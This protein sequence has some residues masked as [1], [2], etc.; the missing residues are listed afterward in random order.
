MTESATLGSRIS[1]QVCLRYVMQ[2]PVAFREYF[3]PK[4]TRRRYWHR[5]TF[6]PP[7]LAMDQG[8]ATLM[9][10]RGSGKSFA[11]LEPEVVRQAIAR[12]GE[13]TMLTSLRKIH[14]V[15]RLER[16][17]DYF[18]G[19]K[20]F[21]VLIAR[22]TRSPSYTI[23]LKTNHSIYGISVGDDPEAKMAQGKHVSTL[24]VE[25]AQQYPE[26][27]WLKLQGAK[28]PRGCRVLM[29]GVPDGAMDTPFRRADGKLSS[30]EGRRFR[31][32]RRYDPYFDKKTK[33]E[34]AENLGGEEQDTFQQE[35][36]AE[37]AN[38]SWS[39]WDL[40]K[41][42][43]CMDDGL[44]KRLTKVAG[45]MY[46]QQ[47]LTPLEVVVDLPKQ[48]HPGA[49][50]YIAMDVGYSQPSEIGVLEW[51][52]DQW[53]LI[54]R[55][56]LIDRMEHDDQAKIVNELGKWYHA[57]KIAVDTTEGEGRAIA[58]MLEDG[59]SEGEPKWKERVNRVTFTET[60]LS[61]YTPEGEEV[62][63]PTR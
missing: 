3:T 60:L 13:E 48:P 11:V 24:I 9:S 36:D 57:Q 27:A 18:E 12:P 52:H 49:P 59:V 44:E 8:D 40:D 37:W 23:E 38:P 28:D 55:L 21:K 14:V 1:Q 42:Y 2:H 22:I 46:R 10:G 33:D 47:K 4:V 29:A 61:G 31:L 30:F 15:D 41:I 34:F 58:I 54:A 39:A 25:E 17:I 7:L 50:I 45:R 56:E 6:T 20:I 19:I 16:A 63:E 32:S 51:W 43:A 53:W 26:R 35:V 62:Y 5:Y